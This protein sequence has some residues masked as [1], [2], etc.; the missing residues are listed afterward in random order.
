MT[1]LG[2]LKRTWKMPEIAF[3]RIYISKFSGG[4]CPRTSKEWLAPSALATCPPQ[5]KDP[6]Y[7]TAYSKNL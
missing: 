7:G 4:A 6:D 3:A 5:N 1:L 2:K